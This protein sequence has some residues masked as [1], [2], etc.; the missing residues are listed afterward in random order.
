MTKQ[1][2]KL[3]TCISLLTVLIFSN[4]AKSDLIY[5]GDISPGVIFGSGNGNGFFVIDAQNDIEVALRAKVPYV[6]EYN[7]DGAGN[8]NMLTGEHPRWGGV[9]AAWNFEFAVNVNADGLND[10]MFSNYLISLSIDLDPSISQNFLTFD[11][12]SVFTDN[13]IGNNNSVAQNSMNIGWLMQPF[14]N[15]V[16]GIYDFVLTVT[17]ITGADILAETRMT[18]NVAAAKVSEP[19][20]IFILSMSI[21]G[22]AIRR[23]LSQKA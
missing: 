16:A 5:D 14:D 1:L 8:Y 3:V 23:K 4:N 19:A 15:S 13:A 22:L 11:P 9:G 20:S 18:V 17:D 12:V 2:V 7:S 6:S 10:E 21:F